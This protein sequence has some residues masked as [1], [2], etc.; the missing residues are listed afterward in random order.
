MEF[1]PYFDS[2]TKKIN[3]HHLT[4]KFNKKIVLKYGVKVK[5]MRLLFIGLDGLDPIIARKDKNFSKLQIRSTKS[6][7][8]ANTQEA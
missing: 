2:D 8:S 4:Q 1:S 6:V 7:K 3:F 5:K